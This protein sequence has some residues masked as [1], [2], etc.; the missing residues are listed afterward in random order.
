ILISEGFAT[1]ASL[2]EATG[3]MTVIAFDA[4]NLLPAAQKIRKKYRDIDIIVC[5]D[6]DLSGVGQKAANEAAAAVGGLVH[7]PDVPGSDWNDILSGGRHD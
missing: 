2:H 3:E 1:G 5:G 6:N 4:N 7:I